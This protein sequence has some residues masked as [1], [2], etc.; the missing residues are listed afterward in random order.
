MTQTHATAYAVVLGSA[1]HG[2]SLATLCKTPE[3]A[4]EA[5]S[6]FEGMPVLGLA[7]IALEP[8][9]IIG[10]TYRLRGG[11]VAPAPAPAAVTTD[12]RAV[13]ERLRLVR[14]NRTTTPAD[15]R[16]ISEAIQALLAA[17]HKRRSHD[18]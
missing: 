3:C 2:F 12:H 15:G 14:D 16:T 9:P 10:M 13:V 7:T 8:E 5:V 11:A 4:R 6:I 17:E 18:G 1:E